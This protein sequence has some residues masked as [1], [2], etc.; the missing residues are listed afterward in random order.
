MDEDTAAVEA[1]RG[2]AWALF[3]AASASRPWA[4][5]SAP[6]TNAITTRSARE[7]DDLLVAFEQRFP[8][9]EILNPEA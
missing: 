9:N 4:G 1:I 5:P 3:A 6:D 7:A 8:I 2:V